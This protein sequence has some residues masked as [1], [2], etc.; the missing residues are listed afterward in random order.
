MIPRASDDDLMAGATTPAD[1]LA[2]LNQAALEGARQ[3]AQQVKG[4][5]PCTILNRTYILIAPTD[6]DTLADAILALGMQ[7]ERD[8]MTDS[9]IAVRC[10]V[11]LHSMWQD[12][13]GVWR[14][15]WCRTV[16]TP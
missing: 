7:K 5:E 4:W 10:F 1:T 11:G 9:E 15:R 2:V 8:A 6:R 13:R 14:C 16:V 3:I 12:W